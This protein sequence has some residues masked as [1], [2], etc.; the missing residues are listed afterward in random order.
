M[1]GKQTQVIVVGGGLSGLTAAAYIA[2]GGK[3]VTL[4][5][6]ASALGGRARTQETNGF[7][8]NM[9]P[10]A[11]YLGGEARKVLREFGVAPTGGKPKVQ[12]AAYL[13]GEIYSIPTGPVSFVRSKLL[14]GRG[15]ME[16]LRFFSKVMWLNPHD[17]ARVTLRGWLDTTFRQPDAR[18]FIEALARTATYTNAPEYQGVDQVIAQLQIYARGNVLYMDGGWQTLV[19]D[20]RQAATKQGVEIVTGGSVE[21]VTFDGT[22]YLVK[23]ANGTMHQADAVIVA[24]DPSTASKLIDGGQHPTLR[25]WAASSVP[26]RAACL[27]LGLRRLPEPRNTL[28]IGLDTPLY[29]SVHSAYAKLAPGGQVLIHLIKYLHPDSN[30]TPEQDEQEMEALLDLV[31]PGWREQVVARSYLPRLTVVNALSQAAHGG[32]DARPGPDVPGLPNLYVVGDW[33]G[34]QGSLLDAA[35]A[36]A[37]TASQFAL[38]GEAREPRHISPKPRQPRQRE[39]RLTGS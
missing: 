3:R 37:R 16:L 5:E 34:K 35:L 25:E 33:V 24:T 6:K 10:H 15:K 23:L 31:Q 26:V 28:G 13:S 27:N 1:E 19:D 20:M 17:Y 8:F 11:L 38:A 21:S 22:R 7:L 30:N 12:G 14:S 9:G 32:L 36:S 39:Y 29:M 2:R 4:F 18:V